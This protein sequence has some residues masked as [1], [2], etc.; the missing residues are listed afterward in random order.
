[1]YFCV[2]SYNYTVKN[3]K[4]TIFE[5]TLDSNTTY[6]NTF[7]E[8]SGFY[9]TNITVPGDNT[10][11]AAR[12]FSLGDEFFVGQTGDGS[13]FTPTAQVLLVALLPEPRDLTA[14]RAIVENIGISMTNK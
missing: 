14:L 11:Y 7:G 9:T 5:T 13:I 10:N 1:M 4:S 8:R 6:R 2:K 3:G 12:E